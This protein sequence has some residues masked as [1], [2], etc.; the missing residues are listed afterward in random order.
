MEPFASWFVRCDQKRIALWRRG[1]KTGTGLHI[2]CSQHRVTVGSLGRF[3]QRRHSFR[4]L[5]LR[6]L[7]PVV[8]AC[9]RDA[10]G[11]KVLAAPDFTSSFLLPHL[12]FLLFLSYVWLLRLVCRIFH[13]HSYCDSLLGLQGEHLKE[14]TRPDGINPETFEDNMVFTLGHLTALTLSAVTVV[15]LCNTGTSSDNTQSFRYYNRWFNMGLKFAAP[16]T[17]HLWHQSSIT[18]RNDALSSLQ[19]CV[20]LTSISFVFVFYL[21]I[22]VNMF[23]DF[24]LKQHLM[25]L[26]YIPVISVHLIYTWALFP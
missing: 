11:T 10:Q 12:N 1:V 22:L 3:S 20:C 16:A 21:F 17:I 8:S 14:A 18:R 15:V 24:T 23:S 4:P 5:R 19:T 25:F 26:R 7:F 9:A 6:P 2:V 13:G